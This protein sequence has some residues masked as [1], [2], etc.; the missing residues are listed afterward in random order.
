MIYIPLGYHCNITY[1]CQQLGLKK[2]SGLF[3]WVESKKLQYITDVINSIVVDIN[4]EIIK[5]EDYN[6]CILNEFLYTYHY[7]L[8][9]YKDIF[10]RRARRFLD[11]IKGSTEILFVRINPYISENTS[12]CELDDFLLAIRTINPTLKVRFLL[13]DTIIDSDDI[14]PIEGYG[15]E[16]AHRFLKY[17]DC[18]SDP[19]LR[20]NQ[21]VCSEIYK[22]M[23][24]AGYNP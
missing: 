19:Y 9:D 7:K 8:D 23:V 5:G 3:E 10:V 22:Y 21:V 20:N 12:S 16:L 14:V 1:V 11:L 13:I 15:P 24:E 2:E 17:E 18:M 6:L 4:T